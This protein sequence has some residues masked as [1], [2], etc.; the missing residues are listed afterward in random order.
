ML[1]QVSCSYGKL[2]KVQPALNSAGIFIPSIPS[3]HIVNL[4]ITSCEAAI[5][6][7]IF[8]T[9]YVMCEA[10]AGLIIFCRDCL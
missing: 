6:E 5:C 8:A 10:G 3:N 9:L 7:A 1:W 4:C 2:L